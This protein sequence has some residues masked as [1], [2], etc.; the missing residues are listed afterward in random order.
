MSFLS[1]HSPGLTLLQ[2]G[3]TVIHHIFFKELH[4]EV[5]IAACFISFLREAIA[6]CTHY[7]EIF[8]LFNISWTFLISCKN[9]VY[10]TGALINLLPLVI[11]KETLTSTC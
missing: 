7:S 10:I 6:H 3:S 1:V 5:N 8:L 2:I 11:C 4:K 9:A